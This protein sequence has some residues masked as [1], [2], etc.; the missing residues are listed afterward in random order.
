MEQVTR[1]IVKIV[2][3]VPAGP[4][5]VILIGGGIVFL[6]FGWGLYRVSLV[7]WGV[8][9]GGSIGAGIALGLR[10]GFSIHVPT[11]VL[12]IPLGIMMGLIA[13]KLEKVGAFFVGGLCGAIPLLSG[14]TVLGEGYG[15]YVAAGLAFLLGGILA[16][17]FWKPMIILSLSVI[18]AFLVAHGALYGDEAFS[19][20]NLRGIAAAHPYWTA[21]AVGLLTFVG[22]Y[23]QSGAAKEKE[24]PEKE[25]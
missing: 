16:V 3:A 13:L 15:I 22:V 11:L 21:T 17:L 8:L 25:E 4:L 6:F 23:F 10:Y 20:G 7:S 1:E 2:E 9:I 18:G 19:S 12:S 14:R 5:S 24:G